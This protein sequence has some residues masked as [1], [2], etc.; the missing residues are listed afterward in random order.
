MIKNDVNYV[1]RPGRPKI[2]RMY[3]HISIKKVRKCRICKKFGHYSK[4]CPWNRVSPHPSNSYAQYLM[5]TI[6]S[7]LIVTNISQKNY[8][9]S[10]LN[11]LL[12]ISSSDESF[13]SESE[14]STEEYDIPEISLSSEQ[15]EEVDLSE[16]PTEDEEPQPNSIEELVVTTHEIQDINVANNRRK[17]SSKYQEYFANPRRSPRYKQT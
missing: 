2:N 16:V 9:K 6:N 13:S 11:P 10:I 14:E 3:Q 4:S 5:A 17:S 7:D 8:E 12:N 1:R 15:D